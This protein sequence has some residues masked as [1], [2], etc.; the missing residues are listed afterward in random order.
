[1]RAQTRIFRV[2]LWLYPPRFRRD[3]GEPMLQLFTDRLRLGSGRGAW[4]RTARDLAVSVPYEYWES[5]MATSNVTR[6]TITVGVTAVA[7]VASILVGAITVGLLLMLLLAWQLYA[8]LKMRGHHLSA[9]KWW[10]FVLAG[11]G[12]FTVIFVVFALPWPQSW[13]SQVPGDL[14]FYVVMA[15]IALSIVLVALGVIAGIAQ[16]AISRRASRPA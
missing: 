6:V 11:V 8:I 14:A 9:S 13:R 15:G 1:M 2:L 10:H 4:T 3:Y 16:L 7:V 12:V 5:F